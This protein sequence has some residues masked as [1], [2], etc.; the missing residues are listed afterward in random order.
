MEVPDP[1]V[2]SPEQNISLPP[3]E[4]IFRM[5][6]DVELEKWVMEKV[7][8]SQ[9]IK[10]DDPAVKSLKFPP[11]ELI[12]GVEK[13]VA[14]TSQYPPQAINIEPTYL[15][16][17]RL[18]FEDLNS[19]RYGWDLGFLQP[20]LS[21]ACFYKDVL[22]LPSNVAS[23]FAEGFWDT[24]AGKCLPG[25]PTPFMLYPPGLTVTGGTFEGVV[26]TGLAFVLH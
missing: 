24:N 9:N 21:A 4:Q 10:P 2:L 11:E 17:R 18:L 16:H 5:R 14:K 1:S 13:Y 26:V 23:G 20:M 8:I 12:G 22:L 6:G 3:R 25:S 19:E 7:Q 15:I